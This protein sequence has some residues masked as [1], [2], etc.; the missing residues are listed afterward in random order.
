M[1]SRTDLDY[2]AR[3]ELPDSEVR[4]ISFGIRIGRCNPLRNWGPLPSSDVFQG[5]IWT[6]SVPLICRA[7]SFKNWSGLS[8]FSR[9]DLNLPSS[10]LDVSN[11][12]QQFAI[13]EFVLPGARL[14]PSGFAMSWSVL[15]DLVHAPVSRKTCPGW[16]V[17]PCKASELVGVI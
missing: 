9:K 11:F 17:P 10:L 8:V 15:M 13:A 5:K 14:G 7:G 4:N 2:L 12:Q 16:S 1:F 3:Y 6:R